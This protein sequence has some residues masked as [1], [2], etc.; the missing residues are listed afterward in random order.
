MGMWGGE[1]LLSP[2]VKMEV[3]GAKLGS[4]D[5]DLRYHLQTPG[6][7][8]PRKFLFWNVSLNKFLFTQR[9]QGRSREVRIEK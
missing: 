6:Q 5:D 9:G 4:R 2:R 7:N 3:P 1:A 8:L